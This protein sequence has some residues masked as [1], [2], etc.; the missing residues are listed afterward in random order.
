L[1]NESRLKG[2]AET[3]ETKTAEMMKTRNDILH[4]VED[5]IVKEGRLCAGALG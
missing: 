2:E 4:M 3:D 1:N 5:N